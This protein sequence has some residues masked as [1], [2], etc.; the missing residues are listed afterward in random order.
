MSRS[1]AERSPWRRAAVALALLGLATAGSL[2]AQGQGPQP[3]GF[4]LSRGVERSLYSLQEAWLQWVGAFY[5]DHPDKATEALEGMLTT[6]RQ[7]GMTRLVDLS[8]GVT[9]QALRSAREGNIGR[10][11]W[12]LDAAERL[13][14]GRPEVAF[15]RARVARRAGSYVAAT[16]H[17]VVGFVRLL[18]VPERGILR[19]NLLF[20]LCAVLMLAAALFVLTQLAAKGSALVAD[21]E[22]WLG[23]RMSHGSARL[24]TALLLLWPLALPAGPFWL[25]LFWSALLW[26]YESPSERWVSAGVWLVVGLVPWI[27]AGEVKRVAL[28]QSPPARALSHFADGRLYGG[29]FADLQV[30]ETALAGEPVANELLADVHRTLGQWEQAKALYRQVIELEPQNAT[31]L[32]NIGAYHFRRG[33][34]AL[35]N[36]YFERAAHGER[37]SAAALYDLS[38]SFSESYQFEESREALAQAKAID[39]ELVDRWVQVPNPDRVLTFNGGLA[40]RD[41]IHRRLREVW[42]G[43][44]EASPAPGRWL[45]AGSGAA[46]LGAAGLAVALHLVRR[47]RGYGP[48]VD[49]LGWRSGP[50]SRWVRAL[51][52]ALSLAELGEGRR[53]IGNL[54]VLATLALLP[55]V[56]SLGVE[57]PIG[58]GLPTGVASFVAG[59]ALALYVADC[60]RRELKQVE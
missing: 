15:A 12:A 26:G 28:A 8:L 55:F 13:D 50:V 22:R 5:S 18:A 24:V 36:Q 19:A 58:G 57:L 42:A 34:F 4:E 20:W 30:L 56:F 43:S 33:D 23:K 7:L 51:L 11:Q 44:R 60:V 35:A 9:A 37:P 47:R 40:R 54:L 48:S 38:L 41:E 53:E 1:A 49:W 32:I 46:G 17:V 39:G 16:R 29:L 21:L 45:L 27:A 6:A 14:P 2:G 59:L 31:A 52:P 3:V 25:L 10:A